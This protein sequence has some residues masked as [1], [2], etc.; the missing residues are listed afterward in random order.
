MESAIEGINVTCF[1]YGMTGSGKTYTVLGDFSNTSTGEKGVSELAINYLFRKIGQDNTGTYLVKMSYLEIYN[2]QVKDLLVDNL[3]PL[4]IMEDPIKG[5]MVPG[6]SEYVI[7]DP[8][9]LMSHI[10]KGNQRRAIGETSANQFSSRSHVI[11]QLSIECNGSLYS[12]LLLIDL[13]GSERAA[14]STNRGLRQIEG[15]KINC[16]LL[17]L[18]ECIKIL[19]DRSEVGAFVP[20][21]NSKLTRLLKESLGGNTKTVMI[22]CISP[23]ISCYEETINTLK[24][25]ERAKKIK[26]KVIKSV[27]DSIGYYMDMVERL[28]EEISLLK[29]Q[30]KEKT[31]ADLK[32]IK[33]EFAQEYNNPKMISDHLL[34]KY[35]EYCEMKQSLQELERIEE[36]N[37]KWAEKLKKNIEALKNT[38]MVSEVNAQLETEQHKLQ[39]LTKNIQINKGMKRSI[40][41]ALE[42]NIIEQKRLRDMVERL[43]DA[44]KKDIIE[45]QIAIRTLRLQNINLEMQNIEIK[46]QAY[47][48]QTER[49][50]YQQEISKVNKQLEEM[51]VKLKEKPKDA[52]SEIESI[53]K[54]KPKTSQEMV[55]S[56]K[57]I[58]IHL[59]DLISKSQMRKTQKMKSSDTKCNIGPSCKTLN[60]LSPKNI[61]SEP[62][63]VME[64]ELIN[65]EGGKKLNNTNKSLVSCMATLGSKKRAASI[66][67]GIVISCMDV[68]K[69]P[70][71][72][73]VDI[74]SGKNKAKDAVSYKKGRKNKFLPKNKIQKLRD[75]RKLIHNYHNDLVPIQNKLTSVYSIALRQNSRSCRRYS[76]TIPHKRNTRKFTGTPLIGL[77]KKI[78]LHNTHSLR[79][80]RTSHIKRGSRDITKPLS[81]SRSGIKLVQEIDE[82]I[83]TQKA[84]LEVDIKAPQKIKDLVFLGDVDELKGEDSIHEASIPQLLGT[85]P[86]T[87]INK[88][89]IQA[90]LNTSIQ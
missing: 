27:R 1:A 19:S 22:S 58:R 41:S 75:E 5:I 10:M 8:K 59:N 40:E 72:L 29:T 90:R 86:I 47:M 49:T 81:N 39:E 80:R 12:K 33:V 87:L 61:R 68:K 23:S 25:A 13:A 65:K 51:K 9:T 43:D 74:N 46:R 14:T 48:T 35:E 34:N 32:L 60:K 17:A 56:S 63:S 21:R 88:S 24:Y 31:R 20:Y 15:A 50:K 77:V 70:L 26:K 28:K 16:S 79:T 89:T 84:N 37:K 7:S 53:I 66:T 44:H 52:E 71:V 64:Y 85:S 18:G 45:L 83:K 67:Q 38:R 2:E 73:K 11:L 69:E 36:S 54:S 62:P 42:E 76:D 57:R 6:L 4:I 78:S 55:R 30:L 82:L 3:N